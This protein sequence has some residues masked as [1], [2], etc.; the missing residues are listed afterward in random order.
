MKL[1]P[2]ISLVFD[3]RCE[4]AF[5]FYERCLD[6]RV[7]FMLT[8]RDSP[9]A[10][11]APPGWDAKILHATLAV[12]DTVI[13]GADVAPD[14]YERPGGFC[15]VLQMTDPADAERVFRGLAENGRIEMPLEETFWA[16]RFGAVVDQFGIPWS[17]NCEKSAAPVA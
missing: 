1:Q 3:G 11:E 2:H 9:M 7:T 4:A 6:V 15:V 17:I 13:T 16:A 12:G 8:W 10:A 14:K 5:R